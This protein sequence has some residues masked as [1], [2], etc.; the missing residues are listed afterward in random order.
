MSQGVN[1]RSEEGLLANNA[2]SRPM[3]VEVFKT[4][5]SL[6]RRR[7]TRCTIC[8]STEEEYRKLL[9]RND[10]EQKVRGVENGKVQVNLTW[11]PTKEQYTSGNHDGGSSSLDV[12]DDDFSDCPK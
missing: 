6:Q 1:T 5:F 10:L 8:S 9:K 2:L 4:I 12:E 3:E 11:T 7:T